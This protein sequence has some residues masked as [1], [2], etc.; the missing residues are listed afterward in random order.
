M[1]K[2]FIAS[3]YHRNAAIAANQTLLNI[4]AFDNRVATK[5]Q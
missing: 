2:D 5:N 3:V 1:I 4:L